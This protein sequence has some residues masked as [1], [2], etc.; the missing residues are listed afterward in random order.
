MAPL[1]MG[2]MGLWAYA[3]CSLSAFSEE[4]FPCRTEEAQFGPSHVRSVAVPSHSGAHLRKPREQGVNT[5]II[6][7]ARWHGCRHDLCDMRHSA[8]WLMLEPKWLEPNAQA[9][10]Y[11]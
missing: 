6:P 4:H 9:K 10:F 8:R 11:S 7:V 1:G 3:L 5:N 2:G